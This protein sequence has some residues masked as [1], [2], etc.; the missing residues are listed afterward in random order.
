VQPETGCRIESLSFV[1]LV[2]RV[3]QHRAFTGTEPKESNLIALDVERQLCSR[4]EARFCTAEPGE[5][6]VPI[7][8]LPSSL[9]SKR[10]LAGTAALLEFLRSGGETVAKPVAEARA[11]IC[12]GCPYNRVAEG[13]GVCTSLYAM[14]GKLVPRTRQEPGLL[15]C[16]IC[17]CALTAKVLM[18]ENVLRASNHDLTYPA[19]CWQPPPRHD[20]ET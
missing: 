12:R 6:Y 10:V 14:I 9:T 13:C 20:A 8:D 11:K 19:Y 3:A 5:H 4:L 1:E 7:V 2:E 18:P 16:G 15:A 17:G